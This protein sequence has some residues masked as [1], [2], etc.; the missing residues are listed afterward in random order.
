VA[1]GGR[2]RHYHHDIHAIEREL[3]RLQRRGYESDV[4]STNY[5]DSEMGDTNLQTTSETED[6]DDD[7]TEDDS[8]E[9]DGFVEHDTPTNIPHRNQS[10]S[11]AGIY[12]SSDDDNSNDE[13][14]TNR[15][16]SQ[17]PTTTTNAS[18]STADSSSEVSSEDESRETPV[19]LS[20]PARLKRVILDD[21]DEDEGQEKSPDEDSD[22]DESDATTTP[23]QLTTSRRSHLQGRR[24]RRGNPSTRR[25][26]DSP[27]RRPTVP[28]A[29]GGFENV[30]RRHQPYPLQAPSTGSRG[31]RQAY[32]AG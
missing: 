12:V 28:Y 13:T 20:R 21:S 5:D 3:D 26:L 23:A 10:N 18:A 16:S 17:T 30:N 14:N 4:Q 9:M 11:N 7:K 25:A 8:S 31:M 6:S 29:R 22:S 27:S 2:P 32:V 19:P 15:G 24:V 1:M